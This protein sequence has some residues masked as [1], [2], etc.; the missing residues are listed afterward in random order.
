VLYHVWGAFLDE[1]SVAETR[2]PNTLFTQSATATSRTQTATPKA[3]RGYVWR[4]YKMTPLEWAIV[5]T[6]AGL[7]V[8]II[9]NWILIIKLNRKQEYVPDT[10]PPLPQPDFKTKLNHDLKLKVE[11]LE[12][13]EQKIPLLKQEYE[14]TKKEV[15]QLEELRKTLL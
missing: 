7:L 14:T 12:E 6:G 9:L 15:H 11:R 10:L 3:S 4:L 8:M 13:I 1:S 2:K 5:T